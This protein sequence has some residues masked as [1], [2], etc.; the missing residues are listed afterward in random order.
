MPQIAPLLLT[1]GST[2]VEYIPAGTQSG[3]TP[4]MYT[5]V[6]PTLA[7]DQQN[8]LSHVATQ[9]PANRTVRVRGV[10][11]KVQTSD[12]LEVVSAISSFEL[13]LTYP[14]NTVLEDRE[15][16]L[17]LIIAYVTDQKAMLASAALLY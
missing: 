1:V 10:N 2:T 15:H 3:D 7:L 4:S 8:T 12:G 11:K 13:K 6:G 5:T 14:K 9:G 17:D 16:V